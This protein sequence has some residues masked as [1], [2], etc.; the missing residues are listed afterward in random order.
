MNTPYEFEDLDDYL[1]DR[2]SASDKAAFEQTLTNDPALQQR[3][4]ALRAESSVLQLLRREHLLQQFEQWS[5]E[6]VPEKK[7]DPVQVGRKTISSRNLIIIALIALLLAIGIAIMIKNSGVED[8]PS[9]N[10]PSTPPA[11]L[12]DTLKNTP[13]QE[14][15][16]Q[17]TP[18]EELPKVDNAA[19]AALA[20]NA[21]V[22]EDFSQTLMGGGGDDA[23]SRYEQ[24]VDFY[25]KKQYKKALDLLKNP[26]KQLEQEYLYLRGYTYYHLGQYAKAE[27]DFK[28]FRNFTNSDRKLDAVW[29]EVFCLVKQL[30]GSISR[31]EKVL[32][33]IIANPKHPYFDRAQQLKSKLK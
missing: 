20:A 18:K 29:C 33:E 31:L 1:N 11:Q 21:Y 9:N 28:A 7:T 27:Q 4:D 14:P 10:Q 12:V 15:I 30:P 16:A 6:S 8:T 13:V 3:L 25:G 26:D 32:N 19:Y 2:M 17:E 23:E 5:D 22:E 24:A